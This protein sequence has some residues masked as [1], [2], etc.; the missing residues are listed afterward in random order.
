MEEAGCGLWDSAS[1]HEYAVVMLENS[2]CEVIEAVTTRELMQDVAAT[3]A[4]AAAELAGPA[5]STFNACLDHVMTA[6]AGTQAGHGQ[7]GFAA[8]HSSESIPPAGSPDGSSVNIP[9]V[10]YRLLEICFGI[11]ANLCSFDDLALHIA[12]LHPDLL[13][14]LLGTAIHQ[15][16]NAACLVELCRLGSAGLSAAHAH[17]SWFHLLSSKDT[18]TRLHWIATSTL[19]EPLLLRSLD[20][21][22]CLLHRHPTPMLKPLLDI[23]ILG[24]AADV[25]QE[26]AAVCVRRKRHRAPGSANGGQDPGSGGWGQDSGTA[27]TAQPGSWSASDDDEDDGDTHWRQYRRDGPSCTPGRTPG[28]GRYTPHTT[29]GGWD[30]REDEE[31]GVTLPDEAAAAEAAADAAAGSRGYPISGAVADATLRLLEEVVNLPE[32]K[33]AVEAGQ[34]LGLAATLDVACL[35]ARVSSGAGGAGSE[36]QLAAPPPV[37]VLQALG[38]DSG[39]T[40]G[41][42]TPASVDGVKLDLVS[43]LLLIFLHG[44]AT[45]KS[46]VLLVLVD[47]STVAAV[48]VAASNHCRHFVTQ[49][50][51]V[52]GDAKNST[53]EGAAWFMLACLLQQSALRSTLDRPT[54]L[55]PG[56]VSRSGSLPSPGVVGATSGG[57]TWPVLL[58]RMS[59][60][61]FPG[62]CAP[63]VTTCV[64]AG[65]RVLDRESPGEGRPDTSTDKHSAGAVM[66]TAHKALHALEKRLQ[67]L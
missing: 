66:S 16:N 24:L 54:A 32:G 22:T 3:A 2:M 18:L 50:L 60:I 40:V 53:E 29:R 67:R 13:Q 48:R 4:A 19:D 27:P 38:A 37:R 12:L 46:G 1:V 47:I 10:N 31:A 52:C 28:G 5:L 15:I 20:L 26:T 9:A 62:D 21:F 58:L 30:G 64:Q 57:A 61:P 36:A 8:S 55:G 23:G 41:P 11:L 59:N 7:A 34:P 39:V 33:A 44:N 56:T 42:A 51:E 63:Y 49:L 43:L 45:M 14:L 65:L 35:G 6:E 25:L 17:A